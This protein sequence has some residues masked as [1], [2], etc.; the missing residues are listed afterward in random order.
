MPKQELHTILTLTKSLNDLHPRQMASLL[1]SLMSVEQ[2]PGGPYSCAKE[3]VENAR[4]NLKIAQL[5]Y[6]ADT[7]LP[8]TLAYCAHFRH[9][10]TDKENTLF[11][12]LSR[13]EGNVTPPRKRQLTRP[14]KLALNTLTERCNPE[15]QAFAMSYFDKVIDSDKTGEISEL[16][17]VF[18]GDSGRKSPSSGSKTN[19]HLGALNILL[20]VTFTSLDALLD[21]PNPLPRMIAATSALQLITNDE[22]YRSPVPNELSTHLITQCLSANVTETTHCRFEISQKSFT[23]VHIPM[24]K[25]LKKLLWQRS[26][27]HIT[28]I[29][30]LYNLK[31]QRAYSTAVSACKPYLSAKQ[32]SDDIHDWEEDFL[33]GRITYVVARLFETCGIGPGSHPTK[34]SLEKLREVFWSSLL[35]ELLVECQVYCVAAQKAF[36]K[37]FDFDEHHAF[38]RVTVEPILQSVLEATSQLKYQEE[39][40][41]HYADSATSRDLLHTI[42]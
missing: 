21:E 11:Q 16:A 7:P 36:V 40:M 24:K 25:T 23:L 3:P 22:F 32:L 35:K 31:T 37:T 17:S 1:S 4:L 5:F 14:Q 27:A 19:D 8:L 33:D 18:Y 20:W 34:Q 30:W 29:A 38:T 26:V 12:N 15:V 28:S 13:Q 6:A 2:A 9:H 42:Q 39:F 10:F 41:K